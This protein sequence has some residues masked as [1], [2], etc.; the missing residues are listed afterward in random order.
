MIKRRRL[1]TVWLFLGAYQMASAAQ[2]LAYPLKDFERTAISRLEGYYHSLKTP[3]GSRILPA[4]ARLQHEQIGLRLK[5][6]SRALPEPEAVFS[7]QVEGL[8]GDSAPHVSL[9]VLDIS[10][11]GELHYGAHGAGESFMLASC[12]KILVALGVLGK[13]AEIYPSDPAQRERV[14]RET[15]VIADELILGDEHEVPFWHLAEGRIEHRPLRI[16]DRANLWTYLDWMMSASSNAAGSTVMKELILMERFG[17]AYSTAGAQKAEFW[18]SASASELA[19]M[20]QKAVRRP[21]ERSG[22]NTAA[23]MHYRFFTRAGQRKVPSRGSAATLNEMMRLLLLLEQGRLVDEFSS[24]ELKRLLYLTQ[25]RERF[26][27]APE[28]EA[29]AVYLKTGSFYRC[30]PERGYLCEKYWGNLQNLLNAVAIVEAPAGARAQ[31]YMVVM[32]SNVLRRD[33]AALHAEIAGRLQQLMAAR[34]PAPS[35]F[36]MPPKPRL[37]RTRRLGA[38]VF[39]P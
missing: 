26:A 2:L 7:S 32:S 4:G 33:S 18:E 14:L 10:A 23:L 28:L 19:A 8:L 35:F 6:Q 12:G 3:S 1:M 37:L 36:A 39:V 17:A 13:L 24:L 31:T 9:A 29:A 30:Q 34:H 5:G 20:L 38:E 16:G 25:K 11:A 27:A 22:L 15:E 21:L